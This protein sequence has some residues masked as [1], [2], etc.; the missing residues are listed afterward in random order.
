MDGDGCDCKA[1]LS[2]I[3]AECSYF[4]LEAPH[5]VNM[6]TPE[7]LELWLF[8]KR[9][10]WEKDYGSKQSDGYLMKITE[11]EDTLHDQEYVDTCSDGH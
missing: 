5:H 4:V 6:H 10:T 3:G 7:E 8:K 11:A 9:L 2:V 1:F